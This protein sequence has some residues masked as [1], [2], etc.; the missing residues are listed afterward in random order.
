MQFLL[1]GL[2][3]ISSIEMVNRVYAS[4]YLTK[5]SL[6]CAVSPAMGTL[7]RSEPIQ[8]LKSNKNS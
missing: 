2:L 5:R 8:I 7:A 1:V 6:P 3:S 4:Y